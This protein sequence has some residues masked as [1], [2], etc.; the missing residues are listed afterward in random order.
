MSIHSDLNS[1]SA[2]GSGD[3]RRWPGTEDSTHIPL[4][5]WQQPK[6]N[7]YYHKL[8]Q[9]MDINLLIADLNKYKEKLIA[10]IQI[11]IGFDDQSL[12]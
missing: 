10:S 3:A 9:T 2:F 8:E 11:A 4:W 6:K 1:L 7:Y 12:S 5:L